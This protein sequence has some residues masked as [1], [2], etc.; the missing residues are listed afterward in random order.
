M[1]D[2]Q[3]HHVPGTMDITAQEKTYAGFVKLTIRTVIAI[4]VALIL[5][6]LING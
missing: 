1:A 4:I 2:D 5:L 6:A 3:H